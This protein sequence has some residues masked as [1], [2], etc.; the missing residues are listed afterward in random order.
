MRNL[1]PSNFEFVSSFGFRASSLGC[2]GF[3][4]SNSPYKEGNLKINSKALAL[5]LGIIWGT[6]IFIVGMVNLFWP[7][8]GA[9]ALEL[10]ASIYPG[11]K[12]TS[13]LRSVVTATAYS[14][15]DAAL[16]GL[17][18]GWLYN[19]LAGCLPGPEKS[20]S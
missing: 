5:T 8:Y 9:N 10:I 12:G 20:G 3:R 13:T 2:C 17:V 1:R 16:F 14:A 19:R 4:L 15:V 6:G 18:I 11:Y 7:N